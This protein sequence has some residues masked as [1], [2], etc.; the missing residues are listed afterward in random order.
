MKNIIKLTNLEG[1]KVKLKESKIIEIIYDN[2]CSKKYPYIHSNNTFD[3]EFIVPTPLHGR[4]VIVDFNEESNRY[5]VTKGNGLTYFPFGFIKTGELNDYAWGFLRKED[6]I[7]DY[8]G[9]IYVNALGISTNI[10]EAV[11][12]LAH[13]KIKESNNLIKI[14]PTI[15]QYNVECPYRLADIPFLSKELVLYYLKNWKKKY[16]FKYNKYY[17]YLAE[18]L[19]KNIRILHENDVLHNSI[20]YHNYSLALELLDFELTRTPMTP[21]SKTEDEVIYIKLMNREVI[22]SLE[23]INQFACLIGESIDYEIIKK[24]MIKNGF[25]DFINK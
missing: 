6:A 8:N 1:N 5:V 18:V 16:S 3:I 4:S 22:H 14:N 13:I 25:K 2:N 17:C 20:H 24:I 19:I 11:Y 12:T 15:L 10:M 21:Y 7:R 9:C 23:I